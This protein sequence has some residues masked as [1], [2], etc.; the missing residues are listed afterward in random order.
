[1]NVIRKL[2]DGARPVVRARRAVFGPLRPTWSEDFEVVGL[3]SHET[4]EVVAMDE[5]ELGG[6]D[7]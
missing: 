1:M 3:I 7:D 6:G 4:L 5:T 2:M